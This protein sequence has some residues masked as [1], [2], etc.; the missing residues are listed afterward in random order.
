MLYIFLDLWCKMYHFLKLSQNAPNNFERYK[1]PLHLSGTCTHG[2]VLNS[3]ARPLTSHLVSA[4]SQ[5]EVLKK[6]IISSCVTDD[7]ML[8]YAGSTVVQER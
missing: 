8:G 4:L 7:L 3:I 6:A 1:T 2:K 5:P